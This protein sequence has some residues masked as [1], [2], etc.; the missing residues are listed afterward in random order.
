MAETTDKARK[1]FAGSRIDP[2][3]LIV[4]PRLPSGI[5]AVG[6]R[7]HFQGHHVTVLVG[8]EEIRLDD[9]RDCGSTAGPPRSLSLGW[10]R[11]FSRQRPPGY[12]EPRPRQH[13][14]SRFAGQSRR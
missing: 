8:T 7:V 2:R 13:Q 1:A 4:K 6:F 10:P 14:D 11:S 9:V 5:D 3:E 12:V